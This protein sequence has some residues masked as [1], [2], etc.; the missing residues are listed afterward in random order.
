MKQE[1]KKY[2]SNVW[3]SYFKKQDIFLVPNLLCYLRIILVVAFVVFYLIPFRMFGNELAH[4]YIA[5][6]MLMIAAYSDFIDGYIART[7]DMKSKFGEILDPLADK[8]LQLAIAVVIMIKYY[9]SFMVF[10]MFGVF[11]VKEITLF[12][13][14]FFLA[15][16]K[17]TSYGGAKWYGKVSSFIFYLVTI[18]VLLGVPIMIAHDPEGS[19][20]YVNL[21]I[22]IC[23]AVATFFLFMAWVLYF[24]L[25]VK[26]MKRPA[27]GLKEAEE[28]K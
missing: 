14:D 7:F 28:K 3:N 5:A 26:I 18:F 13:E 17:N 22:Q 24:V 16:K 15:C 9:S 2:L 20:G 4:I 1:N 27:V 8:F 25:F 6:G 19:S 10:V 21:V 23:C 11:M 12:F